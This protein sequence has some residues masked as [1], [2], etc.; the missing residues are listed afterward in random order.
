MSTPSG[1]VKGWCPG[2]LRPM[3][4]GD[5]L[6]VRVRL[7]GGELGPDHAAALAE[8]AR[9]YGN[10]LIDLTSRANLQM[11]GIRDDTL[12]PLLDRLSGLGLLDVSAAAE[13][14]RNVMASPLAGLDPSAPIDVQPLVRD[15][16]QA[17]IGNDRF[18]SLPAKF[19]FLLDGGGVLPLNGV[20]ADIALRAEDAGHFRLEAGGETFGL[21]RH[22]EAL[23]AALGVAERFLALRQPDERRMRDVVKR[24]PLASPRW[25][26]PVQEEVPIPSGEGGA[27]PR[28]AG[29][30]ASGLF[31]AAA[32]PF[33]RLDSTSSKASLPLRPRTALRCASRR[34]VPFCWR[35]LPPIS[36]PTSPASASSSIPRTP[37]L[38]LPLAPAALLVYPARFRR[39]PMLRNWHRC[40]P[41]SS[42]G[43]QASMSRAVPRAARAAPRP[44][45]PSW[46]GVVVMVLPSMPTPKRPAGWNR[47]LWTN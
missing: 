7:T 26:P 8:A 38:P 5:G 14:V 47:W 11:R 28:L 43:E 22:E 39:T 16:E 12:Q 10:G 37:V 45:L 29:R 44:R 23:A 42:L 1:Q 4:S 6:I 19:G 25:F 46:G 17:L 15:L 2:A 33:G 40:W 27:A 30:H 3:R 31:F 21:V 20:E 24:L 13:Q 32:A 18:H 36:L 41:I 34:G 9:R 35:R